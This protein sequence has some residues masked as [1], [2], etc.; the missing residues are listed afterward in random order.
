[1]NTRCKLRWPAFLILL[2]MLGGVNCPEIPAPNAESDTK[3]LPY[4][5]D[6]AQQELGAIVI[7]KATNGHDADMAPGPMVPV[8][9]A[10]IW[11]YVVTN[12]GQEPL[13]DVAV[14]D[15]QGVAVTCPTTELQP[16]E[17]MT[18]TGNGVAIAGQYGNVGTT[19][20]T[21]PD[22][23]V[24]D[25]SDP[26]HY[27]GEEPIGAIEIEKAT[28]GEDADLAPGP[29]IPEGDPVEW[30]YV[31]INT[32][33]TPLTDIM[34]ADSKGVAVTCPT[35]ELA[36]GASMTC[37]GHGVA[38]AGQ[39]TN[40]GVVSGNTPDGTVVSDSDS[41][42]YFGSQPPL[43]CDAG[44][45]YEA[46]CNGE[47]TSIQLDGTGSSASDGEPLT[48]E[49]TTDCV[50]GAFDDPTSATPILT[51]DTAPGCA[52]ECI[53]MLTVVDVTGLAS[54]CEATVTVSDTTAPTI[55]LV[56]EASIT[57]ECHM[58][59]Y[60]EQGATV[61]DDCDT[62][63]ISAT[64][65]GDVV[66][67]D[68]PGT[69]VVT[70][71][72]TDSCDN[73]AEQV[74]RT[75]EVV[76][77]TPPTITLIGDAMMMVECHTGT[78]EEPGA[79]VSDDCDVELTTVTIGGDTVD[80]DV[81]GT[82]IITYDAT[83]AS[84]N[85]ATQVTRIVEVV[86]TAPPEIIVADMT[87]IWPPNHKY[88][89]FKLSDLVT[90]EDACE[91]PLDVDAMGMI[92]SIYSDEPEDMTGNGDGHT[93]NDIVIVSNSEFKVRAERQGAG[94]GR[95]YGVMFSIMDTSGNEYMGMLYIGVPHDQAGSPPVDDGPG[96]GYIVP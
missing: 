73:A 60:T 7:E 68:V 93:L 96:A 8:G 86:D 13:T 41:S 55:E 21:L 25:D 87:E 89:A 75:V 90:A 3:V 82:Y 39:Y 31:V 80:V 70:Y 74:T 56:G 15:D 18:C 94:N 84:G 10:V 54:E 81:P 79:T 65:G 37:T 52:V 85:T 48:Y 76:D 62:T 19:T 46:E 20:G 51:I 32:G 5:G 38:I 36:P 27:F 16:G 40:M 64:V 11:T 67:V 1:M 6:I 63:L 44:G 83:D 57:L 95:V 49:W 71:D 72:A 45:P 92:V 78:Y 42:H 35:T 59:T 4:V 66:D 22:G 29:E 61:S 24:V 43:I 26:S 2:T 9:D 50:G 53:V 58:D 14:T 30:T 17:S 47:S 33:Q 77:T 12:M 23:T 34:V 91:G 28:N 88:H 69:Y